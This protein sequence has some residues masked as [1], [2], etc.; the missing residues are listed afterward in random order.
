MKITY[1]LAELRYMLADKHNAQPAEIVIEAPVAPTLASAA[2]QYP[3]PGHD[4]AN[5]LEIIMTEAKKYH[6]PDRGFAN[7]VNKI[8]MIK[9]VRTLTGYGLKEA[10]DLVEKVM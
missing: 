3:L 6:A 8:A 1:T 7:F 10:K 5:Q 2:P 9:A 4:V